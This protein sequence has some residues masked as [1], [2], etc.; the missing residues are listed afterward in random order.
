MMATSGLVSRTDLSNEVLSAV[1]DTT[2]ISAWR[3]NWSLNRRPAIRLTS[4]MAKF[5]GLRL[6][7]LAVMIGHQQAQLNLGLMFRGGLGTLKT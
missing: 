6:E 1:Q 3:L 7:S 2:A 4:A 5:T